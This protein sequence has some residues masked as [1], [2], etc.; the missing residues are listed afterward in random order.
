MSPVCVRNC[1]SVF[2]G[3]VNWKSASASLGSVLGS[4]ELA[5]ISMRSP[6]CSISTLTLPGAEVLLTT[7]S[8]FFQDFT[9][10]RPFTM[11]CRTTKGWSFTVKCRS[12]CSGLAPQTGAAAQTNRPT[13][14]A[15]NAICRIPCGCI[16]VLAPSAIHHSGQQFCFLL[17]SAFQIFPGQLVLGMLLQVLLAFSNEFVHGAEIVPQRCIHRGISGKLHVRDCKFCLIQDQSPVRHGLLGWG[18][19]L[20]HHRTLCTHDHRGGHRRDHWQY[21]A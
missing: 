7:T 10:M 6:T 5:L 13:P 3:T 9:S 17:I 8:E 11:F 16:L 2:S 20:R 21:S 12:W 1:S 18:R 14:K 15:E 4:R 19:T